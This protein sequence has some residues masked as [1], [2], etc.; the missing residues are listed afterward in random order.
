MDGNAGVALTEANRIRIEVLAELEPGWSE[1]VE[2]TA[3]YLE[4]LGK[5]PRDYVEAWQAFRP[6][7]AALRRRHPQP[8]PAWNGHR[9]PR[10]HA[11]EAAAP[12]PTVSGGRW[13]VG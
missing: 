9:M 3:A 6:S 2:E 1:T 13:F 4:R 8:Q 12:A 10:A 7:L 5:T 11:P